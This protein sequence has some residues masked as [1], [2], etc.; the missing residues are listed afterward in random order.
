MSLNLLFRCAGLT[1]IALLVAGCASAPAKQAELHGLWLK[2]NLDGSTEGF[3]LAPQGELQ[4]YNIYTWL[5]DSW[6][7]DDNEL[8][9]LSFSDEHPLPELS[10]LP[11]IRQ[12]KQLVIEGESYF[13]GSYTSRPFVSICGQIN[14]TTSSVERMSLNITSQTTAGKPTLLVRKVLRNPLKT[15][16]Y[17]L[18][19]AEADINTA[20]S[21]TLTINII[22]NQHQNLS[23]SITLQPNNTAC[24]PA[25]KL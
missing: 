16:F 18:A 12:K 15:S 25:I 20:A 8:L 23:K 7:V 1:I 10:Q 21:Y 19:L 17:D 24:N 14:L 22:D 6:S 11:Y 3:Y 4:F 2:D 13:Q 5:G 9:W